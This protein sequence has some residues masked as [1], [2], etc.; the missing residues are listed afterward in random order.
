MAK[1][2]TNKIKQKKEKSAVLMAI[3][4]GRRNI[5][6]AFGSNGLVS[7]IK[8]IDGKNTQVAIHE[9]A[10]FIIENK[11]DKIIVGLPLTAEG[12][13]TK[14]AMETRK[15]VKLLKIITKKPV[16]F[17]NEYGS[18]K[19]ALNKAI[20]MEIPQRSRKTTDHLAAAVIL[21]SYYQEA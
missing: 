6:I 14:Q 15:F 21:K 7:P 5:G 18:T 19:S 1:T 12:K 11:I 4:Y 8:V 16:D 10:R 13:E 9:I 17:Y 2:K 20:E 3:D